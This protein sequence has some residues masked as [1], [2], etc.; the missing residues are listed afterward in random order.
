MIVQLFSSPDVIDQTLLEVDLLDLRLFPVSTATAFVLPTAGLALPLAFDLSPKAKYLAI[1]LWQ[2]FPVYQTV[3]HAL[4]RFLSRS[5]RSGSTAAWETGAQPLYA[6]HLGWVYKFLLSLTLLPHLLVVG[7]ILA[8]CLA[9]KGTPLSIQQILA[10]DSLLNPPTLALTSQPVP[11][12][13]S[14][15]IVVSFLKWDVYCA[16]VSATVWASCTAYLA[17][18]DTPFLAI[19]SKVVFWLLVGGPVAP[20]IMLLWARDLAF[21][22]P[23]SKPKAKRD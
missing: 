16:C 8:S 11:M 6:R 5:R 2:P 19:I 22:D 9:G 20:A 1:A 17:A 21:L 7:S 13:V 4:A 10:P 18:R 15:A 3:S 12:M 14:R 23:M